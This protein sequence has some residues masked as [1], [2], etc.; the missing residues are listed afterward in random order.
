M[1]VAD[2]R[3]WAFLVPDMLHPRLW[4][5]VVLVF[6]S[7]TDVSLWS[8]SRSF[9][10]LGRSGA[11]LPEARGLAQSQIGPFR[12]WLGVFGT[13]VSSGFSWR[14]STTFLLSS[15]G[16]LQLGVASLI[17]L[18][19]VGLVALELPARMPFFFR[20]TCMRV[21]SPLCIG[22]VISA[23]IYKRGVTT[24]FVTKFC[25]FVTTINIFLILKMFFKAMCQ[26][27]WLLQQK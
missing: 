4:R 9:L 15:L 16:F 12:R 20:L 3:L 18:L 25:C 21:S 13:T 24:C 17:F 1:V 8:P 27:C 11:P 7:I 23:F 19:G 2:R 10:P 26:W 22:S 6:S 14:L 5:G